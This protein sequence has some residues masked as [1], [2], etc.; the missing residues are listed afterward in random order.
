[1]LKAAR[2]QVDA[3]VFHLPNAT[4][5][6]VMFREPKVKELPSPDSGLEVFKT[7]LSEW[8]L[9][10]VHQLRVTNGKVVHAPALIGL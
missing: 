10:R 8:A 6:K 7:R 4:V 1:M 2:V 3:W 5:T 9:N